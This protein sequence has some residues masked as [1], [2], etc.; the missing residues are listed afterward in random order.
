[1]VSTAQ[2]AGVFALA[3]GVVVCT[4]LSGCSEKI[5][6][7][8]EP[9]P[10]EAD[11]RA[12]E[13]TEA[14]EEGAEGRPRGDRGA[15]EEEAEEEAR[16]AKKRAEI[17]ARAQPRPPSGMDRVK[18]KF[19]EAKWAAM[20]SKQR[21][22]AMLAELD[23]DSEDE[24][25]EE[26]RDWARAM[27]LGDDL[28][29]YTGRQ[30]LEVPRVAASEIS[31]ADFVAKYVKRA[32]PVVLT[33][34]MADWPAFADAEKRWTIENF[35]H[36]FGD[37]QVVVDTAGK[38]EIKAIRDYLASFPDC[39]AQ[40][41]EAARN[42][43]PA[44]PM[45]YLRTWYFA[46]QLPELVSEFET[47]AHF[48]DDAFRRLPDDMVPPFQW[49]FFGP[50]G[51]ESKLHVD[52]W[53]TDAWLGNLE[54]EKIFTLYH[55]SM[56]PYIER[57]EN[58]WADLRKPVDPERFPNFHKAVPAQT[59]LRAGEI[60]YIPRRWPHHA[61]AT[62]DSVSLTLNFCPQM[63]QSKVFK[64]LMPYMRNRARC[65]IWMGRTLRA[66]DN[67]M[68]LCVHGGTLKY[69]PAST[70]VLST[71]S[72]PKST[73][74]TDLLCVLCRRCVVVD[75]P[76]TVRVSSAARRR[77]QWPLRKPSTW[78]KRRSRQRRREPPKAPDRSAY[79]NG[80]NW[81]ECNDDRLRRRCVADHTNSLTAP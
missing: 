73:A 30:M 69:A 35:S 2:L 57:E 81:I 46:D 40:L 45:P 33:G 78:T 68:Q 21:K 62:Q 39:S 50:K 19:G 56:R 38:K 15:I 27:G 3:A 67:L 63:A 65:Q 54:G 64:H 20:T 25:P 76:G 51:T 71:A 36:R 12:E 17:E 23:S 16:L 49:L 70:G 72:L 52:V 24:A 74:R 60:L 14:T 61:L 6:P 66:N 58:D 9:E 13:E 47:P 48:A 8:P 79:N 5:R 31:P 18:A 28:R 37:T 42:G 4:R 34:A 75:L 29:M 26:G 1:M 22:L 32:L 11:S 55:P 41:R 10:R 77:I 59:V 7:E 80:S 43:E 44:P 53:E